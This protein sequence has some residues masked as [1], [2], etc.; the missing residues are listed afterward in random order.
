MHPISIIILLAAAVSAFLAVYSLNYPKSPGALTFS[1]LMLAGSIYAF[2]Y[3]FELNGKTISD[4][5]FWLNIEYIGIPLI[6]AFWLLFTLQ[7]TGKKDWL[8]PVPVFLISALTLTTYILRYTNEYHHLFYSK[9]EINTSSPFPMA[10]ITGGVWY[11]VHITFDNLSVLI[12]SLLFI[13]MFWR[14]T[15]IYRKQA[16]I[17]MIGAF[18]TWIP[19]ILYITGNTPYGFDTTPLFLTVTGVIFAWAMFHYR[20]L[21][22]FPIALENVFASIN[23]GVI[24]TDTFRRIINYNKTAELILNN[25]AIVPMGQFVDTGIGELSEKLKELF[26]GD[27]DRLQLSLSIDNTDQYYLVRVSHIKD[28]KGILLGYAL[29]LNDIT[30]HVITE[31]ILRKNEKELKELNATKDKFFSI[32]SHDLRTPFVNL[33]GLAEILNE[34]VDTLDADKIKEFTQLINNAATNGYKLLENLLDWSRSQTGRINCIP[35]CISISDII[36]DNIKTIEHNAEGKR[37]T[38][39]TD[40][41]GKIYAFADPNMINSVVRNLL[42]N[43]VKFSYNNSIVNICVSTSANE[44]IISVKDYGVGIEPENLDKLF[45]ND[46]M[47]TTTGTSNERGTGLGLL[48]AHEFIEKNNGK[49]SVTSE[50]GKGSEFIVSLPLFKS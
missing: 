28:K 35:E 33:L 37:V 6:P 11:W 12:S 32:I 19:F 4:L 48:L 18:A 38:F 39:S 17:M 15:R 50:V 13:D 40:I 24:L 5:T 9:I 36:Y 14:S 3:A 7:F 42:N 44:V 47:F 21:D 22:L 29:I 16:A 30:E 23:E 25:F 41:P 1:V 31:R 20:V 8:K 26:A 46:S 43:A 34:D 10:L 49:I 27:T 45:D 2:G